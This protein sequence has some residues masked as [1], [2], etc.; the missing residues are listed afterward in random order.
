MLLAPYSLLP[1][2][3][4]C[5]KRNATHCASRAQFQTLL[6]DQTTG[7][8]VTCE[9]DISALYNLSIFMHKFLNW[10]QLYTVLFNA[11]ELPSLSIFQ[12]P[13]FI[14]TPSATSA[15]PVRRIH[16]PTTVYLQVRSREKY[17]QMTVCRAIPFLGSGDHLEILMPAT[18]GHGSRDIMRKLQIT[19]VVVS[20]FIH[21]TAYPSPSQ[22][23]F[24][25]PKAISHSGILILWGDI[26]KIGTP[27]MA[28]S[29][30]SV[31]LS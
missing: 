12:F 23:R 24:M 13:S 14:P 31:L 29:P 7:V 16:R 3:I 21:M 5:L 28:I 8:P 26:R 10:E 25:A 11:L 18:R 6:Q 22:G 17:R 20:L 9:H 1:Y 4:P 19:V 2:C 27:V 15:A 30:L